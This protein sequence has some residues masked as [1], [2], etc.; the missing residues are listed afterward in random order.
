MN[1]LYNCFLDS[2]AGKGKLC[3]SFSV[4]VL[5]ILMSTKYVT[6]LINTTITIKNRSNFL[7]TFIYMC[8]ECGT[9]GPGN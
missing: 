2:I 1:L 6:S 9:L 8:V 4:F 3:H 5:F 7:F